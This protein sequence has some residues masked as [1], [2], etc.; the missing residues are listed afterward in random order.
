MVLGSMLEL[1]EVSVQA[2]RQMGREAG[3]SDLDALIF[4]GA[5]TE[6][7]YLAALEAGFS[8]FLSWTADF[9]KLIPATQNILQE[10]LS[11]IFLNLL[12]YRCV[13]LSSH[14]KE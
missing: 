6:T 2:H 3:F 13:S 11:D 4:F 9:E 5:E 1:G 12:I 14:L 7:A 10:H 8:G